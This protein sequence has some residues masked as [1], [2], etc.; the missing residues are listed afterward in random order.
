MRTEASPRPPA[1]NPNTHNPRDAMALDRLL[2]PDVSDEFKPWPRSRRM[3]RDASVEMTPMID[4]TFLLL[5]F[6]MVTASL[7]AQQDVAVPKAAY[8]KGIDP[9]SATVI[10]LLQPEGGGS[11]R[12]VLGDGRGEE[13]DLDAVRDWV[14]RGR[15]EGRTKVIVK[16]EG[17]V[18]A[19]QTRR[20]YQVLAQIQGVQ[21]HIGVRDKK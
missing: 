17:R 5:I 18:P 16:A 8:G 13:G 15:N 9:A 14:E 11:T 1:A 6:F 2:S 4:V 3:G 10:T 19:G 7:A 21:L 12:I 20:V